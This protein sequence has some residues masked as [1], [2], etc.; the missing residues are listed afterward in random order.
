MISAS[1]LKV[2]SSARMNGISAIKRRSPSSTVL[3]NV[4]N[5]LHAAAGFFRWWHQHACELRG[6]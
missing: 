1:V 4:A 5:Y 2:P 6:C 3:Q